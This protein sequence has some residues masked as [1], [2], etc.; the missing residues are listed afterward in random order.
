MSLESITDVVELASESGAEA[1]LLVAV[2]DGIVWR[3]TLPT[4]PLGVLHQVVLQQKA[5]ATQRLALS[6]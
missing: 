4:K 3:V 2:A 1:Q 6:K 5:K